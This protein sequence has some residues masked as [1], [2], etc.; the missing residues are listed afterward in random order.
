MIEQLFVRVAL[1]AVILRSRDCREA[2]LP[3]LS[4]AARSVSAS[5]R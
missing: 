1:L 3:R 4:V 5:S 2:W